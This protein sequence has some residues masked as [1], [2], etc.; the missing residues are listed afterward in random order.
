MTGLSDVADLITEF[1]AYA[2]PHRVALALLDRGGVT[3]AELIR[4]T[5]LP[6]RGV[7]E[8]LERLADDLVRDHERLGLTPAT[9][10]A[11]RERFG[12]AGLLPD[13]HDRPPAELIIRMQTIIDA[14][15][16]PV[17]SFDHVPATAETVLRRA[18]WLDR[19]F[20]LA[21]A[22]VLFVGDH[23][24]TSVGLTLVAP[25]ARPVVVDLD[26]RLLAFLEQQPGPIHCR[27]ADL[28]FGL[29]DDLRATADLI[30]TDP[31]YTPDGVRLFLLRGLAGLRDRRLGRLLL[32]YG[33]GSHQPA[34]GLAVQR[35]LT[36][37]A[38]AYEAILPHFNRYHGAQAV[39]SAADLY[40]LR[41]TRGSWAAV[42]RGGRAPLA[43]YTHGENSVESSG[44]GV[45]AAE[46]IAAG[47]GPDPLPVAALVTPERS[48]PAVRTEPPRVDLAEVLAGPGV[49][50]DA[51]SAAVA[52]DATADPGPWLARILLAQSGPRIA[53]AVPNGHPDLADQ[54]G[55]Q[56]L[57]ALVAA[58]WELRFRRSTPGPRL[59]IVE[60]IRVD[61]ADLSPAD[62]FRRAI[63][64]GA[65][66]SLENAW[67]D[68]LVKASRRAG[69]PLDRDAA[70]DRTAAELPAELR[71]TRPITLPRSRLAALLARANDT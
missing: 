67:R 22:T 8:L 4:E 56:A 40:Q 54:A 51:R 45:E 66:R 47:A 38:L 48:R 64:D 70:R 59:A 7:E 55:Q 36:S 2:R 17:R 13:D 6:R 43:I 15:P 71:E 30:F 35:E 37:L 65:H 10:P 41:P 18:R 26:E 31:P 21:G 58:K 20:D 44:P 62:T 68:G 9:A 28:R 24:L 39:G 23:D 57:R 25:A 63:L 27:W 11:Y 50:R 61:P 69:A 19:T 49:I 33:F 3:L 16:A 53:V 46:L 52:V 60:A 5:A 1:G 29:P 12:L 34:L 32:A 14:A 42:D